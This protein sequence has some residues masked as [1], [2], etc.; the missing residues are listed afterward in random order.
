MLFLLCQISSSIEPPAN[1]SLERGYFNQ[2]A[3]DDIHTTLTLPFD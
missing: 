2:V 1:T 3:L